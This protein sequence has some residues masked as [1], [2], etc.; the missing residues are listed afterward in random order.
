VAAT[1]VSLRLAWLTADAWT[2]WR[3]NSGIPGIA[4]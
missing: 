3:T 1:D 4:A 2:K